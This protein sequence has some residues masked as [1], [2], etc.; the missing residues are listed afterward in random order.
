MDGNGDPVTELVELAVLYQWM[1]MAMLFGSVVQSMNWVTWNWG[2]LKAVPGVGS[3]HCC[4][5]G[6]ST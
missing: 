3:R 6:G 4:G 1:G 5:A 2:R